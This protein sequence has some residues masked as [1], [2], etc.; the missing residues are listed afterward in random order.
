MATL[1]LIVLALPAVLFA[2]TTFT[3]TG[4]GDGAGTVSGGGSSYTAST[5]RGALDYINTNR[6][7]IPTA[8]INL[9][10][11]VTISLT[12][13][14][15]AAANGSQTITINGNGS[16]ING[17]DLYRC[18]YIDYNSS[19]S[20][21]VTVSDLTLT[22]GNDVSDGYGGGGIID[23][24]GSDASDVLTLS[25]C[26]V[27]NCQ[28]TG[29]GGGIIMWGGT[30]SM[31]GCTVSNNTASNCSGGGICL[32]DRFSLTVS[33]CTFSGNSITASSSNNYYGGA[34][35]LYGV[36]GSYGASFA[37][38]SF[39]GNS[40]TFTASGAADGGAVASFPTGTGSIGA[41]IQRCSFSSNSVSGGGTG[42]GGA[43]YAYGA[44]TVNT[45][46]SRFYGNTAKTNGDAVYSD[47]ASVTAENNW[48]GTNGGP[49]SSDV[50]FT[51]PSQYLQ[52]RLAP[53]RSSIIAGDTTLLS[54]DILGRNSGGPVAASNVSGLPGFTATFGSASNGALSSETDLVDGQAKA[55][56]TASSVGTGSAQ[57]TA[58]NQTVTVSPT[59]S[60]S[61]EVTFTDGSS[62]VSPVG[63]PS[64]NDNPVGRFELT[65]SVAGATL[66]SL[67]VSFS[68]TAT[69][70]SGVNLWESSDAIF[71]SGSDTKINGTSQ[72]YES[73]VTFSGL[74]SSVST[75]GTYYF[76]TLDLGTST[77]YTK[78]SIA[79]GSAV[80]L[81]NGTLS[82]T[83]TDAPL[84]TGDISLPVQAT[85]FV[86][87]P[88][89]GSVT[90]TWR[91]RSEVDNAGFCILRKDPGMSSFALI[92]SYVTTDSLKGLG[93]ST[94]GKEYEFVDSKVVSG[95]TY[96]YR[97]RSVSTSGT[98]R[99]LS[100]LSVTV[101]VPKTYALYQN[102]PNPFNPGTTIRFDLK[103]QS[104]VTLEIYSVLGQRVEYRDYGMMSA[105]RYDKL[106]DMSKFAGG[107]YLYRIVVQGNDGERFVASKKLMLVK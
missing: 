38:S 12:S 29:K 80:T 32:Y 88:D 53:A 15:L 65:G 19:G 33:G 92:A 70:I 67:V 44:S 49:G 10:S 56:F 34:V 101:G 100:L 1:V 81:S 47:G 21:N 8:V 14:L 6:S 39:N 7:T 5:L 103:Q 74:S 43:V 25:N 2:Q 40:V 90:L 64:T 13:D 55:V 84:S 26:T 52:L 36:N 106:V 3:V 66:T 22:N 45:S 71:S 93:T 30:L 46:Y 60:I 28:A 72:T 9:P 102:Y 87:V 91:T 16:T 85:D 59:I 79:N 96:E 99:D 107:T 97:I 11:S 62:Y 57:V 23:G 58:D 50:N 20:T 69:G 31:T 98:T 17:N 18:L 4:N 105:G 86:A 41:T 82:G 95:R 83:I 51:S 27:T 94:T 68:G 73:T 37:N 75:S 54:A 78:A 61:S 63:V 24:T 77:G 104:M 48:W 42:Y 76:V 89:V 35:Y